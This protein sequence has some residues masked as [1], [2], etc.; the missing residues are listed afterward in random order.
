[1]GIRYATR[2]AVKRELDFAETA[3]NDAAVDRA[4][5]AASRDADRVCGRHR[6]GFW[7]EVRT[8]R[9]DFPDVASPTAWRLWL[10]EPEL[11]SV[12]SVTSGGVV[13]DPASVLARP[14]D[15]P[16]FDRIELD[17][18]STSSF[19]LGS[20]PQR[21][22]TITG[23]WGHSLDV[24]SAGALAAAVASTTATTIDVTDGAA[25]GVHD[26]LTIDGERLV[27]TGRRSITTG[28]TLG[29]SGLAGSSAATSLAV[30]D[31]TKF[32]PDEVLTI[33]AERVL[34]LDVV[35]NS[36]VVKR[37]WDGTTLAGHT[38]GATVFASRRLVVT[39]GA[40]GTTAATHAQSAAIVRH[41]W[42]DLVSRYAIAVA[43]ADLQAV[44]SGMARQAGT[45]ER[46]QNVS[47]VGLEGLAD[48]LA[49]A[50]GRRTR[51]AAV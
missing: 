6:G 7:P 25:V 17:R 19:G 47:G 46:A 45:G 42:P 22:V 33:D 32:T 12:A 9:F 14:D 49:A 11:V 15:G 36:L 34:V 35:G 31:G 13:L 40:L 38:V 39:R 16:P 10:D 8:R 4:L 2:E 21:D 24:E 43:A 1:M 18:S 30:Q 37:A 51:H 50:H 44:S 41:A 20:T 5:A 26:L 27:V 3:R 29:G 28:Q 48:R 23:V